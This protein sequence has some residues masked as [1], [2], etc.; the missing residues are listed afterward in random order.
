MLVGNGV[1]VLVGNGVGVLV[2]NGVGVL[3][4][5]GV[6]VLVG[7]G[8]GVLVGNGVGVLVGFGIGVLDA[9][10]SDVGTN[11]CSTNSEVGVNVSGILSSLFILSATSVFSC[12]SVPI[13]FLTK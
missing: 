9:V 4:G 12:S 8:V 3:V 5:N 13:F 10:G 2:G 7:N 6:G 11:S 1:G